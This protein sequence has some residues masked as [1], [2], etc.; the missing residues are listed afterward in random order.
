MKVFVT[1]FLLFFSSLLFAENI[2]DFEMEGISIG[3]SLLDYLSEDEILTEIRENRYMY[4]YLTDDFGEVYLFNNLNHYDRLSFFVKPD[5]KD[6]LI[7]FIKGSIS[8]DDKID[9]CF[10][11]Q[12]EIEKEFSSA[13]KNT[14][15]S[16]G[17]FYFPWD[18]SRE[19][20][21]YVIDF[22]FKNDDFIEVKCAQYK[23]SLKIENNWED[24]LQV[25]IGTEEVAKW[26]NDRID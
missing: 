18:Q 24:S 12:K 1:L 5:D 2:S 6:Y 10:L 25:T 15:K 4:N 21:V 19:S 3:D 22:T 8:Y 9:Q 17:T 26:F 20:S 13:Y 11:K 14:V 7:Y 16:D 23:K